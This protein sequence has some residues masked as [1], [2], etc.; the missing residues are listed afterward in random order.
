MATGGARAFASEAFSEENLFPLFAADAVKGSGG[1]RGGQGGPWSGIGPL[2]RGD[3]RTAAGGAF[4]LN[5]GPNGPVGV[6]N[7]DDSPGL[8][9]VPRSEIECRFG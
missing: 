6:I 2:V 5:Y 1:H 7:P 4:L 3:G 8:F 9:E